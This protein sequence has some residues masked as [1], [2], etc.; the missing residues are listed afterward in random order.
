MAFDFFQEKKAI[1]DSPTLEMCVKATSN[2]K[3]TWESSFIWAPGVEQSQ[4][5]VTSKKK[6]LDIECQCESHSHLTLYQLNLETGQ[7]FTFFPKVIWAVKTLQ[8][9]VAL[10]GKLKF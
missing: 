7:Q 6:P 4:G 5:P 3:G 8:T 9:A 10:E 2:F 1:S